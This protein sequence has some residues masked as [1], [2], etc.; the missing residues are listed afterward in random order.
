MTDNSPANQ[1]N[2]NDNSLNHNATPLDVTPSSGVLNVWMQQLNIFNNEGMT[3]ENLVEME[4]LYPG[5]SEQFLGN[6]LSETPHRQAMEKNGQKYEFIT[7]LVGQIV[8]ACVI[9]M[10]VGFGIYAIAHN[11]SLES[12]VA[13]ITVFSAIVATIIIGKKAK[14]AK[15]DTEQAEKEKPEK[16]KMP[17]AKKRK[18]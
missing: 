8:A 15:N 3:P 10:L 14:V 7:H 12:F 9:L 4:K 2:E 16:T 17:E 1:N 18:K 11:A 5:F 13:C 6:V